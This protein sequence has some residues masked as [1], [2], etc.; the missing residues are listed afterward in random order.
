M[1]KKKQSEPL[2]CMN[3]FHSL[4]FFLFMGMGITESVL[5]LTGKEQ[6][7]ITD[8]ELCR[9]LLFDFIAW[10][11]AVWILPKLPL[12]PGRKLNLNVCA[13]HIFIGSRRIGVVV[14]YGCA[15]ACL[16]CM[17]LKEAGPDRE[18]A[19]LVRVICGFRG[20]IRVCASL[21][22]KIAGSL[23]F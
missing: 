17:S 4:F 5:T 1:L 3:C 14:K 12:C 11:K 7:L 21:Y 9:E 19:L 10:G 18:D 2:F 16:K 8:V 23:P 20:F 13:L 6:P 22:V 15:S